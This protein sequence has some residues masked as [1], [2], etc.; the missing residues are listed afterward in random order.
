MDSAIPIEDM[1]AQLTEW[2]SKLD[3]MAMKARRDNSDSGKGKLMRVTDLRS[4]RARTQTRLADFR[5]SEP[6]SVKWQELKTAVEGA[7]QTLS[8]AIGTLRR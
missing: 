7:F 3:Q 8:R 4:M 2:G 1:D 6:G 5:A